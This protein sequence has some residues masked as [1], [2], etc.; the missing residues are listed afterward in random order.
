MA[1]DGAG[2]VRYRGGRKTAD[3]LLRDVD[4]NPR[5]SKDYLRKLCME[6]KQY[7]TP[8]LN[9]QL[10]LHFKGFSKI[11]CLE[12]YTGLKCLWLEGNGLTELEGLDTLVN[13]RG[14]YAQQNLIT[15]IKGLDS[16]VCLDA[17]NLSNNSL[18]KISGL[19]KLPALHTLTLAHNKITTADGIKGILECPSIK[20][21][22]ISH[23]DLEDAEAL[24]VFKAMPNLAVLNL[25]GN[26]LSRNIRNY[27]KTLINELKG[28]QYLDDRPV[29]PKDRAMAEAFCAGGREAE[30]AAREEF[31]RRD[32]ERM[33][34]GIRHLEEI[35]SRRRQREQAG[36]LPLPE[37]D[38]E[39]GAD[40][41]VPPQA[42]P[43]TAFGL[44]DEPWLDVTVSS[45]R[46]QTKINYQ[47]VN[48]EQLAARGTRVEELDEI[49]G[50]KAADIDLFGDD[51]EYEVLEDDE[52]AAAEAA[53]HAAALRTAGSV[54]GAM[55][56]PPVADARKKMLIEEVET[57]AGPAEPSSATLIAEQTRSTAAAPEAPRQVLI[58]EVTGDVSTSV[59]AGPAAGAPGSIGIEEIPGRDEP[60][61]TQVTADRAAPRKMLIEEISPVSTS[62]PPVEDVEEDIPE[63]IAM[64]GKRWLSANDGAAAAAGAAT[65]HDEDKVPD[66]EQ[67]D[68]AT[69]VVIDTVTEPVKPTPAAVAAEPAA[70]PLIEVIG[71]DDDGELD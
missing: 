37:S 18:T 44:E 40:D 58:E 17:I 62:E 28:L 70:R 12:E 59:S 39:G 67:V 22:D 6:M 65:A 3:D 13:L 7:G 5:M 49:T 24:E 10:Y 60:P 54:L 29:F 48:N 71:G 61:T 52:E 56:A 42:S 51:D 41:D 66:L 31:V 4:G 57:E 34:S 19:S 16:L 46:G 15:E 30:R 25:M 8:E 47:P 53:A 43:S 20:V 14:L 11:E 21:L 69:G 38:D 27:R 68:L 36:V 26:K 23:N 2:P 35:A 45:E 63:D 50:P 1:D 32:R 9:D 64:D 33:M 55:A